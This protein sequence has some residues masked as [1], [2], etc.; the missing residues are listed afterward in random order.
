MI[1][2]GKW[3][4]A[5]LELASRILDGL[6]SEKDMITI[7]LMLT[8]KC[9]FECEHCFYGASPRERGD[10][11]SHRVMSNVYEIARVITDHGMNYEINLIGGEPTLNMKK[12]RD[13][14]GTV[15]NITDNYFG[16]VCMTTNGWWLERGR[17]T[18]AFLRAIRP[19]FDDSEEG[20]QVRVS[21]DQWHK[22]FHGNQ[23]S[24][25]NLIDE[26]NE[27]IHD[28]YLRDDMPHFSNES[29]WLY[30]YCDL[31]ESSVC[32]SGIR[33]TFGYADHGAKGKCHEF[34][35]L[36]F[37]PFGKLTD[38]CAMGSEMK[39]GTIKDNPLA[40]LALTNY[41][42]VKYIKAEN[43][44][45]MDC[46]ERSSEFRK[47]REFWDVKRHLESKMEAKNES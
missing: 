21:D 34:N 20:I 32:P 44:S 26:L 46:R 13:V 27:S 17:A 15:K 36:T 31:D 8:R 3:M 6:I 47:T 22:P 39:F 2:G 11:M 37:D 24:Y 23:V 45:C 5:D 4:K 33:G 10:Y 19:L 38:A 14:V 16:R 28:A 43:I 7:T 29:K 35:T 42:R 40:L 41:F 30:A 25:S 9:G 1:S 12:F 18:V